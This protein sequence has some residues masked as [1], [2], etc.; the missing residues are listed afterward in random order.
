[1][2]YRNVFGLVFLLLGCVFI[3]AAAYAEPVVKDRS[4]IAGTWALEMTAPKKDG[5]NSNKEV[6]TWDFHADGTVVISGYNKFLKKD[7]E[8]TKSYE[9]VED[10]VI[11]IKDN[12][13]TNKYRV[14]EK[15]N[16][17]MILKGPYGYYFFEKN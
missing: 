13:G 14:V 16:S 15:G 11:H 3:S 1:M 10:S 5:K 2:K 4:D 17:D 6:S 12:L 8:F 9:I 7:T